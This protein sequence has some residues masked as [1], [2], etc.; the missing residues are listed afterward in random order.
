[1][2]GNG[3]DQLDVAKLN[4][5]T[6]EKETVFILSVSLTIRKVVRASSDLSGSEN[7]LFNRSDDGR[8]LSEYRKSTHSILDSS[9]KLMWNQWETSV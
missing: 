8:C 4:G 3:G 1:M 2:G 9:I 7:E 6:V 5:I